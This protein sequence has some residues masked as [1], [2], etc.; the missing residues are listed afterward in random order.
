MKTK[1]IKTHILDAVASANH[2]LWEHIVTVLPDLHPVLVVQLPGH[3]KESERQNDQKFPS[4]LGTPRI[5]WTLGGLV[6]GALCSS[7]PVGEKAQINLN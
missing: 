5:M 2:D 6:Q 7:L 4:N 3:T 1:T